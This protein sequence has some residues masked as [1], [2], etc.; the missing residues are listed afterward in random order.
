MDLL[1][2]LALGFSRVLENQEIE[3]QVKESSRMV[4][5]VALK[6]YEFPHINILWIGIILMTIGFGMSVVY[7][8]RQGRLK[9][10]NTLDKN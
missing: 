9:A 4:P 2:N 3:L 5:F 7:R 6:V 10:I 8:S 1:G